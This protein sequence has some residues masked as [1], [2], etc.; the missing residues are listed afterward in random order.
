MWTTAILELSVL[1]RNACRPDHQ[2]FVAPLDWQP[3]GHT[4][5]EPDLLVVRRDRI[6]DKNITLPPSLVVEVLSPGTARIDRL[7][8]FSR[9]AEGGVD[10]YWIVEPR[11]PSVQ[12]FGLVDGAYALLAEGAGQTPVTVAE[13]LAVTV[14][15]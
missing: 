2:V 7:L 14:I 3:D 8:K 13:P 10:Q 5:L 4:S 11:V 6:G 15:P 1:L 12:V 9:Y